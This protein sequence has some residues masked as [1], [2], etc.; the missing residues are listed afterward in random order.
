MKIG[1]YDSGLG[2]LTVLSKFISSIP[3][4]EFFYLGDNENAPYGD[5]SE[6]ELR[7][8]FER[9]IKYFY[10]N[11]IKNIVLACNTMSTTL[12]FWA[13]EKYKD[14]K[15]YTVKPVIDYSKLNGFC[16]VFCTVRTAESLAK[17]LRGSPKEIKIISCKGLVELIENKE[18]TYKKLSSFLTEDKADVGQVVLGCT[19]YEIIRDLFERYYPNAYFTDNVSPIVKN[20]KNGDGNGMITFLGRSKFF[21]AET[22]PIIYKKINKNGNILTKVVDNY[23]KWLYNIVITT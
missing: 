23:Y 4:N 11:D 6:K 14:L 5:K 2:G 9:N 1:F 21:N 19:H 18:I 17:N 8:I 13:S 15:F 10:D 3:R 22:F 16:H 7:E 12:F 20:F